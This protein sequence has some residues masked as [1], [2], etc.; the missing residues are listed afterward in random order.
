VNGKREKLI[1]DTS[2]VGHFA[3]GTQL[4]GRYAGWGG[5]VIDRVEAGDPAVSIVTIAEAHAG[6]LK[7][8]WGCRRLAEAERQFDRYSRLPIRWEFAEEWAR[9]RAA[10]VASGISIGDND[11]WVAATASTH[12]HPLVSCDRDHLRLAPDL[13][14]EV[15]YLAP[16]V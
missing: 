3:R 5:A 13:S 8:G 12:R 10:A 2:F 1:C 9:L 11:L 16:P 7:A 6:Y 4:L 15:V 14:V